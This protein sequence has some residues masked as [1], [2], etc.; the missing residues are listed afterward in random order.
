MIHYDPYESP[1]APS[2]KDEID[3]ISDSQPGC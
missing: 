2:E 3:G 1:V